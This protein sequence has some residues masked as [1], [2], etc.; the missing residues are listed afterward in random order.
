MPRLFAE[1][2]LKTK[3]TTIMLATSGLVLLLASGA[4]VFSEIVSFRNSLINKT[5]ALAKVIGANSSSALLFH[6]LPT[7]EAILAS[8]SSEPEIRLALIFDKNLK[9]YAQYR[10]LDPPGAKKPELPVTRQLVMESAEQGEVAQLFTL[11]SLEVALPVL[12]DGQ[13]LGLVYLQSDLSALRTWLLRFLLGSLLVMGVVLV[14]AYLFSARLQE[15]ISRPILQLASTMKE[16][17]ATEDFSVRAVATTRDEVGTLVTVFNEMLDHI[18]RRDQTLATYRQGLEVQV[19]QRTEELSKTNR[20]L[21]QTVTELDQARHLAEAASQAKS[22][23]LANMSHEIRTPMIGVLGMTEQLLRTPLDQNQLIMARTVHN[24]GEALLAVLNDILDFS[25]IEAGKLELENVPFNLQLIVEDVLGLFGEKAYSK[26]VELFGRVDTACPATLIGD[27]GRIRQILLNLVGNAVKFTERG[28]VGLQFATSPLAAGG[29]LVRCTVKDTGIGI[30]PAALQ[31]LFESFSQGDNSTSRLYGGT[32]LGLAI[33]R[34]LVTMMGGQTEVTSTFNQGSSFSFSI[35]FRL[36]EPAP[37]PAGHSEEFGT[38]L[39]WDD[40]TG[41]RELLSEELTRL[42]LTVVAVGHADEVDRLLTEAAGRPPFRF[43]LLDALL[44]EPNSRT[45]DELRLSPL[46]TGTRE[47]LLVPHAYPAGTRGPDLAGR[48]DLLFKPLRMSILPQLLL[49]P[50][51]LEESKEPTARDTRGEAGTARQKPGR[52]LVAED[53]PTT[54]RLIGLILAGYTLEMVASGHE[55]VACSEAGSYD[56]ILMDCQ[57]PGM[58]GF[59]AT[60]AIRDRGDSTPIVAL[61]AHA[62]AED[63]ERCR[64]EGMDDYLSKPFKQQQLLDMVEKWLRT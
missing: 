32:G 52:I 25:K 62:Q 29:V 47:I 50:T 41:T 11:R 45:L 58:D 19:A 8:L 46:F 6:D 30:E 2:S 61:T 21:Q 59:T 57:M 60:R 63:A 5:T 4:Y 43:A 3:L 38:V 53:N 26:G 22:R 37:L 15:V 23:F 27:P 44:L 35:P 64:A 31:R 10:A 7:A 20:Q 36:P 33:V 16:V 40:H 14:I 9:P 55:A 39:V 18:A 56:L 1:T 42:G 28:E 34:Q 48:D 13:R 51:Q 49:P 24:S 12:L 17:S 54:Q